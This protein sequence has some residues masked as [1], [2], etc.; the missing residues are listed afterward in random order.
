MIGAFALLAAS[1]PVPQDP[2]IVEQAKRCGLKPHH[3]VWMVDAD[4]RP[5]AS[6]TPNGDFDR[7]FFKSL[8]CLLEWAQRTGTRVGFI[9]EPARKG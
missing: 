1:G 5:S 4:G 2:S 8:R 9:S 7:H 3:I 6:V